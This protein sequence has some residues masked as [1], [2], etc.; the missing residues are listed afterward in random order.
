M[1]TGETYTP[2]YSGE[3]YIDNADIIG[4]VMFKIDAAVDKGTYTDITTKYLL[5]QKD[6]T[7][8]MF[9]LDET[10]V[11]ADPETGE[12]TITGLTEPNMK[13]CLNE[14]DYYGNLIEATTADETGK[15]SYTGMLELTTEIPVYDEEGNILVDENDMPIMETVQNELS[16]I[17][18]LLAVDDN[19]NRSAVESVSVTVMWEAEEYTLTLNTNGGT[20]SSGKELTSYTVGQGALLPNEDNITRAGYTFMGWYDNK[21]LTGDPVISISTSDTGEKS[22]WAK[23]EAKT[24]TVDFDTDGGTEIITDGENGILC[25]ISWESIESAVERAINDP[26][27]LKKLKCGAQS[28]D[29]EKSNSDI[30]NRLYEEID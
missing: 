29:F 28:T 9:S 6:D 23:W 13:V 15:F 5:M 30:M 11:F 8:P 10:V 26:A 24:Y 2:G 17:V 27:F 25:D 16:D 22:Y 14:E 3:F 19:E 18:S 7:A 4:S 12:Y 20:I 1:D 21:D